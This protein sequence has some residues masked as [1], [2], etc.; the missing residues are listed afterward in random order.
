MGRQRLMTRGGS[1]RPRRPMD[2]IRG[3]IDSVG[4][5]QAAQT[6][7]CDWLCD[8]AELRDEFTDP[9]LMV[10]RVA[11]MHQAT[12]ATGGQAVFGFGI[13]AWNF[14]TDGAGN[15]LVPTQCPRLFDDECQ[16]EDWIYR[17][18]TPYVAGITGFGQVDGGEASMSKARRRLGNDKGLLL[19]VQSA[20][21]GDVFNY[22]YHVRA[23]IKE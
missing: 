8:P 5:G 22:H 13:I 10:V 16:D 21:A 7:L 11:G 17:S 2:W 6:P 1:A 23:L 14:A 20:T 4:T 12:A 15:S 3:G 19:V 9:T 18:I